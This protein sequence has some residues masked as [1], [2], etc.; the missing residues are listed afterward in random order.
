MSGWR[1]KRLAPSSIVYSELSPS[2]ADVSH[3][4]ETIEEVHLQQ[5]RGKKKSQSLLGEASSASALPTSMSMD[6]DQEKALLKANA[7]IQKVCV[8]AVYCHDT[9]VR[10][11][12]LFLPS[13]H[14]SFL[15]SFFLS[16]SLLNLSLFSP[17]LSSSSRFYAQ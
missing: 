5:G 11:Y 7:V 8:C 14:S 1:G 12:K 6:E 13:I 2:V 4:L 16:F 3:D 9:Y 17:L 10:T 15:I